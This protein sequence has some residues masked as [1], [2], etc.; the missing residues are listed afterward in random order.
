MSAEV[1]YWSIH[2]TGV[3]CTRITS[4]FSLLFVPVFIFLGVS[5][6]Y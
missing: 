2:R 1:V 5:H 6:S 3:L 4:P